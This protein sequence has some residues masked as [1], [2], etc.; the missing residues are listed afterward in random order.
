[1]SGIIVDVNGLKGS[2]S[3]RKISS[4]FRQLGD[5]FYSYC[6][7]IFSGLVTFVDSIVILV[8]ATFWFTALVSVI[9]VGIPLSLLGDAVEAILRALPDNKK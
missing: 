2:S 9:L 1:M 3:M 6:T 7:A 5:A 4:S 8:S